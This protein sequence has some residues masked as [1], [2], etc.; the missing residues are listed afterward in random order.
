M[1]GQRLRRGWTSSSIFS[2]PDSHVSCG[3]CSH[4]VTTPK[5]PCYK[6]DIL[7]LAAQA[8]SLGSAHRSH[9]CWNGE[10]PKLH[11][12][13]QVLI[14]FHFMG[15]LGVCS[16]FTRIIFCFYLI[17]LHVNASLVKNCRGEE[18][19]RKI[20]APSLTP[21]LSSF[22]RLNALAPFQH[23]MELSAF[24]TAQRTEC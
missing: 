4:V 24:R 17:F 12:S 3:S 9:L 10:K 2:L 19:G 5:G 23:R 22:L 11:A 18:L 14:E 21:N 20:R 8:R 13:P 6:L 1:G 7:K 16:A 15:V